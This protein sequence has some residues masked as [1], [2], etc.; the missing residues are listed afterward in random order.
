MLDDFKRAFDNTYQE[1]FPKVLVAMKVA[2]TRLLSQL[3]YGQSIDRV[4]YDISG[5]TIQDRVPRTDMTVD[6]LSDERETLTVNQDKGTLFNLAQKE[7]VQAGPLNPGTVIG[8]QVATKLATFVDADVLA[9]VRNAFST[10]DTGSLTALSPNGAPITLNSTTVPQ[11]VTRMPAMLRRNNQN[12]SNLALVTDSIAISDMFQYLLGKNADFV[13]ALFQN[14]YVNEQVASAEVY[15]T[16]NLTGEAVLSL[17]TNVTAGDTITING[18]VFTARAVPALPGEFDIAGSADATRAIIANAI[19]GSATGLNSATGYFEVSA[20]DRAILRNAR[21]TATND[22]DANTLTLVGIGS[23]RLAVSETLTDATD[24]WSKN[25]IHTY[26]GK[27]GAIDVVVQKESKMEMLQ[28]PKQ[29]GSKNI[30][31][32]IIYGIKTFHDGKQKFLDVLIN[33]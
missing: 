6:L 17:A 23:G 19:N 13:N 3:S 18:V 10:F 24:A 33:A 8:G 9:E 21:I 5:I 15:V 1:F 26:F 20:A 29:P 25:F 28:E 7:M 30:A 27:K 12:L 16:E 14:G 11:M 2:N 31:S 32:T 22:D 4:K